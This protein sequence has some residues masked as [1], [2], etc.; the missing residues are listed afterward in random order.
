[1]FGSVFS[2]FEG[3]YITNHILRN[4]KEA[5]ETGKE[6]EMDELQKEMEDMILSIGESFSQFVTN[7]SLKATRGGLDY[8][9]AKNK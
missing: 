3:A 8:I 9:I 5:E 6:S 1:M 7:K 2:G 4:L